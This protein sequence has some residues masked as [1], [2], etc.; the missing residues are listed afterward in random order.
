MLPGA[1]PS[2]YHWPM[3]T[4]RSSAARRLLAAAA[5]VV[6]TVT[7]SACSG[8]GSSSGTPTTL[9]T[10]CKDL[11]HANKALGEAVHVTSATPES[12]TAAVRQFAKEL[13]QAQGGLPPSTAGSVKALKR[14]LVVTRI[15]LA[16]TEPTQFG[17]DL[18]KARQELKAIRKACKATS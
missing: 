10:S 15:H 5:L 3:V 7:A 2:P 13:K 1:H 12:L 11:N 14:Q 6:L 18:Y 8:G 4:Q 17:D 9:N 16:G